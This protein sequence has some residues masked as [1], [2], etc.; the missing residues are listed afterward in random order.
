MPL[1]EDAP[2]FPVPFAA[3]E[4]QSWREIGASLRNNALAGFSPRAF[5][6]MVIARSFAGR[7]QIILNDPEA[8]RHVLIENADNYRRTAATHRLLA[9]VLGRGMLLASGEDWRAQRRAAA[10]F[11]APRMMPGVARVAA[12]ACDRLVAELAASGDEPVDLF[13]QLQLLALDIA[14]AALFSLDLREEGPAL[15]AELQ[16]YADGVGR[17]TLL[18]F[19]LPRGFPTPRSLARWRFRRRWMAR[20]ARLLESRRAEPIAQR[21]AEPPITRQT[22]DLFD[23][24]RNAA[25]SDR[26]L[27]EQ[28]ATMLA[29]AH[30]T[31]AVALF[32]SC[33]I[34][35][36]A[37]DAQRRIAAEAGSLDLSPAGAADSVSLLPYTRAVIDEALR[38]Y[39]PA[40]SIIRQARAR[41][42]AA[43]IAIPPRAV[44]LIV[45]WVL[46]RH[47]K[48]WRDPDLFVPERFLPDAEPPTRFS[49]LPF[50][51]GP[52]AC[53]GA[54]FALTEAVLVLARLARE[55]AI[56]L[57]DPHPVLPLALIT[58][59]PDH[60][61]R[62]RLRRR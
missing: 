35:A 8:I 52:R 23:M 25:G 39:P 51:A 21:I 9:P 5:E 18:D 36:K 34:L 37:P 13:G 15:R 56:E 61:P 4:R 43:G 58:L 20:I 40:F 32:W 33:Y 22:G 3:P 16:E 54:Q 57:P 27:V 24:I 26:I 41:D 46:H 28:V 42:T 38:L 2:A 62:F 53:I 60:K 59:Q 6:E 44:L 47:R 17:P 12:Q 49:Y 31:T 1:S 30:E 19:L 48:L 7:Q 45:P 55:F 50:G 11:L 29:A 14:G 10:P